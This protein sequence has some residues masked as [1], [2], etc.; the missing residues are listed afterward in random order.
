M[1]ELTRREV[2][3]MGA[4]LVAAAAAGGR[5]EA[6]PGARIPEYDRLDATAMAA[7]VKRGDVTATELLDE[8]LARLERW[9]SRLNA[10][11]IEHR[12]RA[13]EAARGRLEGPLAGVPFLIKDLNTYVAGTVTSE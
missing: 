8:A 2:L 5:G 9:N 11:V 1:A 10:V 3:G 4:G 13:R 12:D 6:A 7:L